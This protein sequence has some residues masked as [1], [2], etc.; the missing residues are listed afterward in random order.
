MVLLSIARNVSI[1]PPVQPIDRRTDPYAP[2]ARREHGVVFRA[3]QPFVHRKR[4]DPQLMKLIETCGSTHP[5]CS[6]TILKQDLHLIARQTLF[7]SKRGCLALMHVHKSTIICADPQAAIPVT[8]EPCGHEGRRKVMKR[9]ILD[10]CSDEL[11]DDA[12]LHGNDEA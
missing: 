4:G 11:T 7:M 6:F 1:L 5:D 12:W 8:K 3:R 10:A 9:V 2:V